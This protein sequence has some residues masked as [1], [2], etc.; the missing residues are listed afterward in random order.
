MT[1][2]NT[3]IRAL[4]ETDGQLQLVGGNRPFLL[5]DPQ[6][7]WLVCAGHVEV[8]SVALGDG[9][10]LGARYHFCSAGDGAVI[11]GMDVRRFG[12]DHGLLAVGRVGTELRRLDL[13]TVQA[14]AGHSEYA[15]DTAALLDHW[16]VSLSAG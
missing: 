3:G 1:V 11:F 8:F 15:A 4:F 16:I 10:P 7:A 6:S 5:D 2:L 13:A 14:A 12:V 9:Q